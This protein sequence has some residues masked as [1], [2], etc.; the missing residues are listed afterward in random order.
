MFFV[1]LMVITKQKPAINTKKYIKQGIKCT[2]RENHLATM[3]V[4]ME[5]N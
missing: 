4:R 3:T 2:I 1:N 5:N